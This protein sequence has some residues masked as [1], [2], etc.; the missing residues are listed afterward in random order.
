[1]ASS[2]A[3]APP[4]ASCPGVVL[5]VDAPGGW[6]SGCQSGSVVVEHLGGS[7]AAHV[8]AV[9]AAPVVIAD[10]PGVGLALQ[11]GDGTEA[12]AVERRSPALLEGGAVEAFAH[13]VVVRRPRWDA[14]VA[15][16]TQCEA[17]REPGGDVLGPV[18]A[19]DGAHSDP[20]APPVTDH[21][22]D[23]ADG[24][25]GGDRAQHDHH[26]RP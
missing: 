8:V 24:V 12:A 26:D 19:H 11:L 13:G 14:D 18:V 20:A 2:I 10:Q 17:G 9:V 23:E 3:I 4:R 16:L 7:A 5:T 15:D 1:M 6:W 22:V 25:R 21:M